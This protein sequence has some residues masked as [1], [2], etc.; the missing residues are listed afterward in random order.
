MGGAKEDSPRKLLDALKLVGSTVKTT[1]KTTVRI[2]AKFEKVIER[3]LFHV[4]ATCNVLE[5]C[6][7]NFILI[8]TAYV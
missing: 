8:G 7:G 3:F 2:V 4:E 1:I 6:Y 5:L